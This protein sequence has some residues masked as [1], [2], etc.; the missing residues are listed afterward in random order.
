MTASAQHLTG[1]D[2]PWR[3]LDPGYGAALFAPL[4]GSQMEHDLVRS[5]PRVGLDHRQLVRDDHS[6]D[7]GG[8]GLAVLL[9][10]TDDVFTVLDARGQTDARL[11]T[12]SV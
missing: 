10:P 5:L 11:I 6:G 4:P 3:V 8:G 7:G 2:S 12:C 1:A 9:C